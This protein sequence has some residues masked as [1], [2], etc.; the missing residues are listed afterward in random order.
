MHS[1]N[2]IGI[3]TSSSNIVPSPAGLSGLI[4]NPFGKADYSFEPRTA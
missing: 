1:A 2:A 3:Q 4:G